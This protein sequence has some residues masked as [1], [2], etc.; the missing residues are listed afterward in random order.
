ML[1]LDLNKY[2]SVSEVTFSPFNNAATCLWEQWET[3]A[4][5]A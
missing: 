1:Y 5:Q 4:E 3:G 2:V